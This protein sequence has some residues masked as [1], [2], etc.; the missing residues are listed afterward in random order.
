[1]FRHSEIRALLRSKELKEETGEELEGAGPGTSTRTETAVRRLA[2][3][4]VGRKA[5]LPEQDG[6]DEEEYLSFLKTE[7]K[8]LEKRKRR[9]TSSEMDQLVSTRRRVRELD[10]M[11]VTEQIL[12]YDDEPTPADTAKT[13]TPPAGRRIW[14]PQIG[15]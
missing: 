12:M 7:R 14:W 13:Q 6:G 10:E 15:G 3:Q 9:D 8:Q 5:E 11:Q 1:M 2:G 4:D